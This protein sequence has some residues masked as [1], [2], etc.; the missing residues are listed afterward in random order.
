[1]RQANGNASGSGSDLGSLD[2][3]AQQAPPAS[4][5]AGAMSEKLSSRVSS[6]GKAATSPDSIKERGLRVQRCPDPQTLKSACLRGSHLIPWH[7]LHTWHQLAPRS[8]HL[9]CSCLGL[10]CAHA[11]SRLKA[12]LHEL[13]AARYHKTSIDA[14]LHPRHQSATPYRIVLGDVSLSHEPVIGLPSDLTCL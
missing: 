1:M 6:L 13:Q 9:V 12:C 11:A 7:P 3:G 5:K 2:S 10:P 8:H 4:A 14:L